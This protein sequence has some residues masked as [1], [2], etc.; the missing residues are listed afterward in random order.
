MVDTYKLE[1]LIKKSGKTNQDC[2]EHLGITYQSFLNKKRNVTEF[3]YSEIVKL[4]DFI[5]IG[6]DDRV[7]FAK[8]VEL[9]ET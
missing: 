8:Q 9:K 4:A 2:A 7:F 5:G 6:V 3:K 1:Y